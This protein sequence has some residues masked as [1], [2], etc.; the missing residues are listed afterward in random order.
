MNGVEY[1]FSPW[2]NQSR[3]S[4]CYFYL[5]LDDLFLFVSN[6]S[7]TS[8]INLRNLAFC[9]LTC[10]SYGSDKHVDVTSCVLKVPGKANV[11]FK[12]CLKLTAGL[13]HARSACG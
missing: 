10:H 4:V 5:N 13:S 11:R 3:S 8:C 2:I 12:R 7:Y 6:S 1:V 9:R